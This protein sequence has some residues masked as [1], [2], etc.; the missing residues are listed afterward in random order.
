M[1][2][3]EVCAIKN[4]LSRQQQSDETVGSYVTELR[5]IAQLTSLSTFVDATNNANAEDYILTA[6]LALGIKSRTAQ[7]RLLREEALS[8]NEF[9]NLASAVESAEAD[10]HVISGSKVGAV[11]QRGSTP[12]ARGAKRE[13]TRAA[14]GRSHS[15]VRTPNNVC[16]R[17]GRTGRHEAPEKC[18]AIHRECSKCG[19]K[20][21]FARICQATTSGATT[22]I[23]T[24]SFADNIPAV[25]TQNCPNAWLSKAINHNGYS[26][27]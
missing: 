24:V 7:Q 6:M 4:L 25:G 17:C 13:S 20:G 11:A 19:K 16:M 15:R 10:Q 22:R 21:H 23:S 5:A 3:S 14:K 1:K 12:P 9:T 18:P 26:K 8:L 2:G 27:C